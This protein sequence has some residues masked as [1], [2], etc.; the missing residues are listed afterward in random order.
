[1]LLSLGDRKFLGS[2][3]RLT[4]KKC[5]CP[6][7]WDGTCFKINE[8]SETLHAMRRRISGLDTNEEQMD[9]G[10]G[11]EWSGQNLSRRRKIDR[12]IKT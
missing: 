10:P 1:M 9:G 4:R 5:L 11:V 12:K 2:F 3:D 8:Q 6:N 7:T